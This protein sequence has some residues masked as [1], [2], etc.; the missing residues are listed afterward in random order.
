VWGIESFLRRGSNIR[1]GRS[2]QARKPRLMEKSS[3]PGDGLFPFVISSLVS[4][5]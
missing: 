2:A 3:R 5:M 4:V 1:Y